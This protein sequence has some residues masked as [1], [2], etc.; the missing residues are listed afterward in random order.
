MQNSLANALEFN[1]SQK[2]VTCVSNGT[3]ALHLALLALEIGTGD[4]VIICDFSYIAPVNAV[5]YV[6]ATPIIIDCDRETWNLDTSKIS[7]AI[8]QRTKAVIVV[9]NYGR[10]AD[11]S[12][13]KSVVGQDI[14]L[15]LD[16]AESFSGDSKE[17]RWS[18]ADVC[19][20]SFYANKIFTCGEGGAIAASIELIEKIDL[21]KSQWLET[22]HSFRHGG[23]GYNYRITNLSAAIF[24]AQWKRKRQIMKRRHEIF[25]L[26]HSLF[27]KEINDGIFQ[28]NVDA[29]PWLYTLKTNLNREDRNLVRT[30]LAFMNIETRPG[31]TPISEHAHL[32]NR[33]FS[34]H[35]NFNSSDLSDSIISLPTFYDISNHQ[36]MHVVTS[37]KEV[38]KGRR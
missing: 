7:A 28:D 34:K 17:N 26:Y 19:T 25:A 33:A 38:I 1:S 6:G 21:L 37:F 8:S 9:D 14:K 13:I 30:K 11:L 5:L 2:A 35:K 20:F 22:P 32:R 4:E 23:V 29:S 12:A 31:F 16:A 3:T 27:S 36:I 18:L 24:N 10:L 15:V